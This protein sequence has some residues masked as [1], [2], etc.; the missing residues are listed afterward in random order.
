M[1][2]YAIFSLPQYLILTIY[3]QQSVNKEIKIP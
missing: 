3:Y 2:F 1:A